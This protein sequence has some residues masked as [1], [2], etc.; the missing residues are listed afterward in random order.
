MSATT[1]H[2]GPN[3]SLTWQHRRSRVRVAP[4]S[5]S[6]C[7]SPCSTARS[8]RL[9]PGATTAAPGLQLGL[10]LEGGTSIT[11]QPRPAEAATGKVTKEN[12]DRACEIIRRG[13]T[14]AASVRRGRR[15]GHRHEPQH[16]DLLPGRNEDLLSVVK[17]TAEL[18]FR[19]VLITA[20]RAFSPRRRRPGRPRRGPRPH[21]GRAAPR[22]QGSPHPGRPRPRPVARSRGSRR[23]RHRRRRPAGNPAHAVRGAGSVAARPPPS[24]TPQRSPRRCSSSSSGSTAPSRAPARR[25]E[26]LPRHLRTERH[27]EVRPRAGRSH[28]HRRQG[29]DGRSGA[30]LHHRVGRSPGVHGERHQEVRRHHGPGS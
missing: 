3:R 7:S 21:L 28:R 27:G 5:S 23:R 17:Q 10:D 25:P 14:R 19:Q 6:P 8:G 20:R 15:A 22:R 16:R 24:P 2:A 1:P 13:S 4:C 26:E 12:V 18:R 30:E 29:G 11:L 9:S